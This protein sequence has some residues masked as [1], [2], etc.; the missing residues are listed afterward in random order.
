M[1]DVVAPIREEYDAAFLRL[2]EV[3]NMAEAEEGAPEAP[4]SEVAEG[5]GDEEASTL[6][7]PC[8]VDGCSCCFRSRYG[9]KRR[10]PTK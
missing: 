3:T 10:K 9:A 6:V 7:G 8:D 5:A 4:Q 2:V 1:C